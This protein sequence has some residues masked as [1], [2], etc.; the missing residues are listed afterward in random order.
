MATALIR[1]ILDTKKPAAVQRVIAPIVKAIDATEKSSVPYDKG[2]TE[3]VLEIPLSTN[4]WAGQ[5]LHLIRVAQY[6][7]YGWHITGI[8]DD[9]ISMTSDQ[10][11]F[12]GIYWACI[13]A[14]KDA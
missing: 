5:V 8:I 4:T 7:G 10:F 2:G 9:E 12:T 14:S 11:R 13:E 6:L 1:L 3:V